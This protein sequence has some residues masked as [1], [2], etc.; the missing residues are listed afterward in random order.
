MSDIASKVD[1]IATSC[2]SFFS[3]AMDGITGSNSSGA[4]LEICV[5]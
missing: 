1:Y 2:S 3:I 4:S 5:S